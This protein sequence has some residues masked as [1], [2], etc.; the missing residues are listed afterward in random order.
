MQTCP[1]CGE[2]RVYLG[3]FNLP[4]EVC[5]IQKCHKCCDNPYTFISTHSKIDPAFD[6]YIK[7]NNIPKYLPPKKVMRQEGLHFCSSTCYFKFVEHLLLVPNCELSPVKFDFGYR[8]IFKYPDLN[9]EIDICV[10]SRSENLER[11]MSMGKAAKDRDAQTEQMQKMISQ[12]DRKMEEGDSLHCAENF[13]EASASYEEG[14]KLCGK[15]AEMAKELKMNKDVSE[16]KKTL[17]ERSK[18]SQRKLKE[19]KKTKVIIDQSHHEYKTEVINHKGD[20]VFIGKVGDDIKIENSVL[21]RSS[22]GGKLAPSISIC[23]FCGN[24]LDFPKPPKFC[25]FCKEQILKD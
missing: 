15:V 2:K 20:N 22:I 9:T 10:G 13:E 16:M 25:P 17:I 18:D 1:T 14:L 12:I 21:Q 8:M 24:G 3:V 23:P 6:D 11:I 7:K 4:C 5:H 19:E